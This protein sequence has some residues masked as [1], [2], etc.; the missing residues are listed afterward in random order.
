MG[1]KSDGANG[2]E[3]NTDGRRGKRRTEK[4]AATSLRRRVDVKIK[5]RA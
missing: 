5:G 3:A 4:T 2:G 1:E